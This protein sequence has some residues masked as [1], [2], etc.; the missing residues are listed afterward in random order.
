[1]FSWRC[2]PFVESAPRAYR[3]K[4]SNAAPLSSTSAGTFPGCGSAPLGNTGKLIAALAAILRYL[5]PLL[6]GVVF[7]SQP[8]LCLGFNVVS[9]GLGAMRSGKS[10]FMWR[11]RNAA[12]GV[13]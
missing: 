6:R 1:M 8:S 9:V 7:I 11:A 2:F 4:A 5:S 10:R 12:A 13:N 3:L